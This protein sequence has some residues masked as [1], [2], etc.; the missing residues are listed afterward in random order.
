MEVALRP[1]LGRG[2]DGPLLAEL[3]EAN[4][5]R[6][7]EQT[8]ERRARAPP[9]PPP[10]PPPRREQ[11][12]S[13][14]S[15]SGPAT[16]RPAHEYLYGAD[17]VSARGR[18]ANPGLGAESARSPGPAFLGRTRLSPRQCELSAAGVWITLGLTAETGF[19]T[20]VPSALCGAE[21]GVP[22]PRVCSWELGGSLCSARFQRPVSN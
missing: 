8:P 11:C 12:P 15:R 10:P 13:P 3:T 17:S 5:G 6:K 16:P 9:P 7:A 21:V 19:A 22:S 2:V 20:I 18:R 14:T 1:A 4:P